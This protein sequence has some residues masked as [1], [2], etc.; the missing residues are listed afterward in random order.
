MKES[1]FTEKNNPRWDDFEELLSAAEKPRKSGPD[2]SSLPDQL[3]QQSQD[4]AL[5][6]HRMYNVSL[7][8]KLNAQ[9]LRGFKLVHKSRSHTFASILLFFMNTFPRALRRE[10]KLH[11]LC[12]F[13]CLLPAI[14]IL[15]LTNES[16]MEWVNSALSIDERMMLGDT[17]SGESKSLEDARGE[18]GDFMMFAFYVNNNIGID[19][20][21]F[22]GGVFAGV[23][24]LYFLFFNGL[25]LGAVFAYVMHY[26]DPMKL[27]GFV[28][29]HAPYEI[30]AMVIS[31][32]AGVRFGLA[33]L[34]PG[35]RTR[36]A[37]L[38]KAGETAAPLILGAAFMTFF[39]AIIEGFWSAKA[40]T[41]LGGE[42]FK[43]WVGV[44]GWMALIAYF[45]LCGRKEKQL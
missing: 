26:G 40:F 37:S 44:L 27:F 31:G 19:F 16:N 35:R 32:V 45:S 6:R 20:Q 24:S 17:W 12:W 23:G 41:S 2:I 5:S 1:H 7:S 3:Q 28:S 42:W 14:T 22:A 30:W 34:M 18:G 33:I 13:V 29:S 15:T 4:L 43:I 38:R 21:I 9:V 36:V 8:E 10:W 25:K 39:A 11:I